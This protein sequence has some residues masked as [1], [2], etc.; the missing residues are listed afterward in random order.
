MLRCDSCRI[1][2]KEKPYSSLVKHL[3]GEEHLWKDIEREAIYRQFGTRVLKCNDKMA[4][5]NNEQVVV[6]KEKIKLPSYRKD[7]NTKS[8]NNKGPRSLN[9]DDSES[10]TTPS[11]QIHMEGIRNRKTWD[12][13]DDGNDECESVSADSNMSDIVGELKPSVAKR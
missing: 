7:S 5:M 6:S 3:T 11:H 2:F 1:V 8:Q 10:E 4:E 9:L 12:T 13:T